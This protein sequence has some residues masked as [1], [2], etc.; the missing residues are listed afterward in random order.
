M[1]MF[2][3]NDYSIE[4]WNL[5][6]C[7]FLERTIPGKWDSS[8][9][10]ICWAGSR[11]FSVGLSGD[12]LKEW[13]L[14]TLTT[15]R[16]LLLTGEKGICMDYHKATETLAIGT[17]EGIMNI[18]DLSDDDI[19]FVRVL[20]RQ[21]H[22]IICCK[23]NDAG[24]KLV[25]GSL[26]AVKVWNIKTGQV[27]HKMSTGRAEPKQATIVWC[28]DI[29]SDFTI[30]SGDSRGKIIFWDG[31]LGAQIDYVHASTADIMC[32][33]VAEDRKSFFCSGT[34]QVLKKYTKVIITRPD[35][36]VEQWVRNAKRSKIHTHDVLAMAVVGNEKLISGGVDG[37]LS[38][39]SHDFKNFERAGPFLKQ[40]FAEAAEEGRLMVMRYVNYLEVWKLAQANELEGNHKQQSND[41]DEAKELTPEVTH[42]QSENHLYRISDFPEKLLELRSKNDEMIVCSSISNDGHWIAFSTMT[43]IRLFR[44]E[45]QE[46]S[47]PKLKLMKNVPEEFSCCFN[48]IFSKDSST[49]IISKKDG[50]CSVFDLD[51]DAI[52]HRESFDVSEHH[53]D[54]IHQIAISS[55]SKFLVLASLCNNISVWNL[56]RNKWTHAKTLPKH[57][58][59][60]TSIKI[61]SN[62]PVLVVS[63][64][65]NKILEY[66]LDGFF[67]QFTACLALEDGFVSNICLDPR[68]PESVIFCRKNSIN[69]LTKTSEKSLNKKSK[70]AQKSFLSFDV[71]TVKT[72]NTVRFKS[73][74][75]KQL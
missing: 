60:A 55:C 20:D 7:P 36:K 25:S 75:E 16:R 70:T 59:P 54:L 61:R 35:S 6:N 47:K 32:L 14:K 45:V 26:D 15:K 52:E 30:V 21:D 63:Y 12:G 19:Q 56:K 73:F 3:R 62:N 67:I 46:K 58:S 23:F 31:N 27:L 22:R 11:L 8:I 43:S 5:S 42:A 71:K 37:F 18:F 51:S 39:I 28:V 57:S 69:V 1:N 17:E 48:M 40:P 74:T 29:L 41:G 24:D 44:F 10:T 33:S 65:D 49:L 9:E 66:N 34:E 72:F 50:Q 38:F 2:Y 4:I 13:D 68:N 53:T 64:S